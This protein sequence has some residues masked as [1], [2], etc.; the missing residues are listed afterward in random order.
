M[1]ELSYM[2]HLE[3]ISAKQLYEGLL[4]AGLF[5]DTL[6]PVFTSMPFLA[7]CEETR[8]TFSDRP[9]AYITC[10]SVRN[11]GEARQMGIPNPFAYERLCSFLRTHWKDFRAYFAVHTK[12]Q[13]HKISRIH[14]RRMKNTVSLF[15]MTY[16]SKGDRCSPIVPRL[17]AETDY[18]ARYVVETDVAKCFPSI[19]SHALVW[20]LESKQWAKEHRNGKG[21]CQWPNQFDTLVR[22]LKSG[23]TN[24]LMI[25]PHASNFLAELILVRVDEELYEKGYKTLVRHIDDVDYYAKTRE[26]AE[27]FIVEQ[28]SA[29]KAY[30][31]LINN[32]KTKITP[33]PVVAEDDWVRRLNNFV[34]LLPKDRLELKHVRSF[35]DFVVELVT[36]TGNGS[37]ISYAMAIVVGRWMTAPASEYYCRSIFHLSMLYPYLYRFLD[38]RV[39]LPFSPDLSQVK[40]L[41]ERMFE[42]GLE[43]HNYEES[44]YAIYFSIRYSFRLAS[45]DLRKIIDRQDCVLCSMALLYV[46]QWKEDDS[47]LVQYALTLVGDEFS[48][49]ENWILVYEVLTTKQLSA[50]KSFKDDVVALKKTGI[51]FLKPIEEISA[52]F[53]RNWRTDWINWSWA[54]V[55][56]SVGAREIIDG[57]CHDCALECGVDE[58]ICRRYL[59]TIVVNMFAGRLLRYNIAI[60]RSK[61]AYKRYSILDSNGELVDGTV[62]CQ[63]LNWLTKAQYIGERRGSISEGCSYYWAKNRFSDLFDGIDAS[64]I[65]PLSL[66]DATRAPVLMKAKDKTILARPKLS[67]KARLYKDRLNAINLFYAGKKITFS[68]RR[69]LGRQTV[70]PGLVAVFNNE[71]WN[72]GGRLYAYKTSFGINYQ[73]LPKEIRS[74]IEIDDKLTVER[75]YSGLHVALLYSK[76]KLQSVADPYDVGVDKIRPLVKLALITMINAGSKSA[77]LKSLLE[78]K[79]KL[80]GK[81]GLFHRDLKLRE[82]YENGPNIASLLSQIESRHKPIAKYFYSGTGLHLQSEDSAMA[83]EIVSHFMDKGVVVLPV[84]DSFIIQADYDDELVAKMKEVFYAHSGGFQCGVK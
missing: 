30:E 66:L 8:R 57:I 40:K 29:L 73:I 84:H 33:L 37:V 21:E 28:R 74:T 83:L 61:T 19:Y 2:E 70:C 34:C 44:C 20:A 1:K 52:I 36:A 31:L 4:G 9:S 72:Q 35:I 54:L 55:K 26:E 48:M 51:S 42:H 47:S 64:N 15:K 17:I 59:E 67:A 16:Q 43:M 11:N 22:N 65:C 69:G 71:D 49:W 68:P 6:P 7:Y 24:G 45:F 41:A 62:V 10:E 18:S 50:V 60:H 80:E 56:E 12:G 38:E 27:R 75:D 78:K 82:A 63:V 58:D 13:P 14:L 79:D 3:S 76:E 77:A 46:R 23:E 53:S 32:K 39:L 81:D 25:G 5:A